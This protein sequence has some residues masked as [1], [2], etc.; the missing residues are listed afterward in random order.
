MELPPV[1]RK[2]RQRHQGRKEIEEKDEQIS[3]RTYAQIQKT[4][5]ACL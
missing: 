3:L 5:R 2:I 4:A 1:E